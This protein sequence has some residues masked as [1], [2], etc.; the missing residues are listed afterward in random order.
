MRFVVVYTK[1]A[2]TS[3]VYPLKCRD[4]ITVG[5]PHYGGGGVPGP[6][7][8]HK[9][10]GPNSII[11]LA[12]LTQLCVATGALSDFI[13]I[14]IVSHINS[15]ITY[16]TIIR[17]SGENLVGG[18]WTI[19]HLSEIWQLVDGVNTCLRRE[20]FIYVLPF[21]SLSSVTRPMPRPTVKKCVAFAES[22]VASF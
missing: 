6:C 14:A 5:G 4:C 19:V 2:Y 18:D 15:I 22:T 3:D 8:I 21:G 13:A 1:S 7:I 16:Q 17:L 20:I 9:Q 10:T 12:P 11:A